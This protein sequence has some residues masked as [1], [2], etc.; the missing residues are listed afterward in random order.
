V[1]RILSHLAEADAPAHATVPD[2][3]SAEP[4]EL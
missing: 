4:D 3:A 1:S 2:G